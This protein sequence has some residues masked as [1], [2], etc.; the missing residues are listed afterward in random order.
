GP[1]R[2]VEGEDELLAEAVLEIAVIEA[3]VGGVPQTRRGA[4]ARVVVG[5]RG[6]DEPSVAE[7]RSLRGHHGWPAFRRSGPG[8][9]LASTGG[10]GPAEAPLA[11][12]PAPT[13]W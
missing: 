11:F 10:L 6:E 8:V 7:V 12:S 5:L 4:A 1:G 13:R 9:V 3:G 2:Q